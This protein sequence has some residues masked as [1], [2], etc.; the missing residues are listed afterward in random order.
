MDCFFP[1]IHK[2]K[3]SGSI[4]ILHFALVKTALAEQRRLLISGRSGDRNLSA[5]HIGGG[6]AINAAGRL[7]IRKHA[8]GN[9]EILQNLVIPASPVNVKQHG[10]RCVRIIGHMDTALGQVPDQP[11]IHGSKQ[12]LSPLCPFPGTF[13][14]I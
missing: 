6:I 7:H 1:C 2:Q 3:A 8:P 14:V 4:C 10:S 9:S 5:H 12:Q 13:H 11:R